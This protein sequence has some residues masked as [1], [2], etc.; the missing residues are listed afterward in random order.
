MGNGQFFSTGDG[1]GEATLAWVGSTRWWM[2]VVKRISRSLN[3]ARI[4]LEAFAPIFEDDLAGD[5]SGSA[6][7]ATAAPG[8]VAEPRM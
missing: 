4:G 7:D 6:H 1:E 8:W 3:Y 2:R 5:A